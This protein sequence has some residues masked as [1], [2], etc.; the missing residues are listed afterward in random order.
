MTIIHKITMGLNIAAI[1]ISTCAIIISYR[2]VRRSRKALK[3]TQEEAL[4]IT[5]EW[6]IDVMDEI[7]EEDKINEDDYIDAW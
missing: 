2:S 4:K 5:D 6:S 3:E 7:D 1:I